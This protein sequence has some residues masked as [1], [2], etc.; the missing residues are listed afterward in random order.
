[1]LSHADLMSSVP[2]TMCLFVLLYLFAS[3]CFPFGVVSHSC[4][5]LYRISG[6]SRWEMSW[7]PKTPSTSGTKL[8]W[9][10]SITRRSRCSFTTS[11]G[12]RVGTVGYP[13]TALTLISRARTRPDR[14]CPRS[15]AHQWHRM[16]TAAGARGPPTR[17]VNRQRG[18]P[19]ACEI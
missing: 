6:I 17:K 18:A 16:S 2:H 5:P 12:R 1:V 9:C 11:T 14:T 8:R 15:A 4:R 19:L 3:S 13:W 7:T 10:K